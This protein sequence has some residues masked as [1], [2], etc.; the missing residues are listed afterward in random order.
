M[1][2]KRLEEANKDLKA[3]VELLRRANERFKSELLRSSKTLEPSSKRP[4]KFIRSP[5]ST[6]SAGSVGSRTR[7]GTSKNSTKVD[8]LAQYNFLITLKSQI[9]AWSFDLTHQS[10]TRQSTCPLSKVTSVCQTPSDKNVVFRCQSF[11][12]TS[13]A[14]GCH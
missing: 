10:K 9:T 7:F 2:T 13:E 14:P 12:K 3:E 8:Y 1:K 6:N 5:R 11:Y 4:A